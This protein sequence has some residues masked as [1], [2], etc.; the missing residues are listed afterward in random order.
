MKVARMRDSASA[1]ALDAFPIDFRM[2]DTY[3]PRH[4]GGTGTTFDWALAPAAGGVPLVLSGGLDPDNVAAAIEATRPFAVDTAS[5]T[6]ASPGIKD[7]A[8]LR[9]FF[10]A[11]EQADARMQPAPGGAGSRT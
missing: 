8:R 3:S 10:G 6:E 11:V 9:A 1:R 7:P 4:H 5:G 2:L